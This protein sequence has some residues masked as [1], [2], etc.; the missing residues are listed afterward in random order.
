MKRI[1]LSSFLFLFII[2]TAL[3]AQA[4]IY[5]VRSGDSMWKI[6]VKHEI[7]LSELAKANP[8]IKNLA[9]IYPGQNITIPNI[10][11]IKELETEVI[12]L[13]NI[14]RSKRGLQ[15]LQQ[16]WELSRVAR[17][18]SQDMIDK[19]YFAHTS[20]TYGSPFK[21]IESF[22]IKFSAAAENIA[23]GQKTPQ[24]VLNSWMNS[25]GH[26]NNILSQSFY[27]IGVGAAKDSKGNITWTQ[28]FIK[29]L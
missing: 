5:T 7:G 20:P 17:Y 3:Y 14:E 22:G 27:Q 10:D 25:P 9:L 23:Q 16:D 8:Q 15:T 13:V 19:G 1:I 21:M 6:A 26:R 11:S 28:M 29:P 4:G 24:E 2:S 12:R 18:K